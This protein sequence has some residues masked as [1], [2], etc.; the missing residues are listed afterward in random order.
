MGIKQVLKPLRNVQ[1]SNSVAY[2]GTSKGTNTLEV[3]V[4][5]TQTRA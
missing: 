3:F 5:A 2:V 4:R 1:C